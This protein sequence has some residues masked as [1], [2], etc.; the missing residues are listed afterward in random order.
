MRARGV[1]RNMTEVGVRVLSSAIIK[2]SFKD[3]IS[4]NERT[5]REAFVFLHSAWCKLLTEVV[6]DKTDDVVVLMNKKVKEQYKYLVSYYK[7]EANDT[8]ST[9][10]TTNSLHHQTQA[11]SSA[12]RQPFAKPAGSS[13]VPSC[14][15]GNNEDTGA[16]KNVHSKATLFQ[17]KRTRRLHRIKHR[18]S[19]LQ[20]SNSK[21]IRARDERRALALKATRDFMAFLNRKNPSPKSNA[22]RMLQ[23]AQALQEALSR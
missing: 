9:T 19:S 7:E 6:T 10:Q 2:Q 3:L 14:V 16:T 5:R 17:K 11:C 20:K 18:G 23:T 21:T 8:S 4:K 22:G 12:S 15:S 13:K 1:R